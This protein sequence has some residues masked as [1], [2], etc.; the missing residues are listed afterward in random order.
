MKERKLKAVINL[1]NFIALLI[2]LLTLVFYGFDTYRLVSG[3]VVLSCSITLYL[4][5]FKN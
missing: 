1:G 4:N 3:L 5:T 2:A